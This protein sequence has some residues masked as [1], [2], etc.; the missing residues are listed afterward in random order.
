MT[1]NR[2]PA[3]FSIQGATLDGSYDSPLMDTAYERMYLGYIRFFDADGS[4]VTP[5][6]GDV[7]FL[8]ST[9]G[10]N[11]QDVPNGSFSAADSYLTTR[12]I[13]AAVG[14]ARRARIVLDGV[15][16]AVSFIAGVERY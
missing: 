6:T 14:P 7:L 2:V 1:V 12:P 5:L 8:G 3:E 11:F 4:Q 15:T 13:P 9:D 10:V 16:G